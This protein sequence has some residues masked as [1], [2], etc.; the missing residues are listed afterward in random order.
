MYCTIIIAQHIALGAILPLPQ[1]EFEIKQED[2][3]S[4]YARMKK[5]LFGSV[6]LFCR[7]LSVEGVEG[8]YGA[9]SASNS[10]ESQWIHKAIGG[11]SVNMT[12]VSQLTIAS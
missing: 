8:I 4:T 5:A 6:S 2:L 7:G 3:L 12:T 1:N 11:T 9:M 10:T